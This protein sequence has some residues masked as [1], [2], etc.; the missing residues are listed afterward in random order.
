[1]PLGW[2][3]GIGPLVKVGV[4]RMGTDFSK[5]R[6]SAQLIFENHVYAEEGRLEARKDTVISIWEIK[7]Y[8]F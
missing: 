6:S 7:K 3:I 2:S 4:L 5:R 8:V 1:V